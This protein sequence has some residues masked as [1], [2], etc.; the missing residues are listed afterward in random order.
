MA[1]VTCDKCGEKKPTVKWAGS[2]SSSSAFRHYHSLPSWCQRCI[3]VAQL[4]HAK[5]VAT[6]IPE[7]E[8]RLKG[9]E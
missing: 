5:E 7:L 1:E 3:T 8:E 4:E 2:E 9:Y 6:R